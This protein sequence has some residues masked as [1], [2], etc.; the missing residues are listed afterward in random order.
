[1]KYLGNRGSG[2]GRMR[3]SALV[4]LVLPISLA[5]QEP[6]AQSAASVRVA[7]GDTTLAR[8]LDRGLEANRTVH[9]ARARVDAARAERTRTALE[10]APIV[11]AQGAY[12]RQRLSSAGFP[13]ASGAFPDQDVWSAGV[14]LAWELDVFGRTRRAVQAQG[15]RVSAAQEDLRDVHLV[16][17]AELASAYHD[18]RG[19]QERLATAQH[20]ATNQ[21]N[22]LALT[23]DRLAAGRGNAF[24]S[25]RAR[26][27]L[28]TTLAEIPA[29]EGLI[30]ASMHRIAV[31]VGEQPGAIAALAAPSQAS[32]LPD[33][34]VVPRADSL[35]RRRPDVRGAE[36]R[37]AATRALV[38]AARADYLPRLAIAGTAGYTSA[39]AGALGNGATQR[40]A[41]GPVV[42]WPALDLGRVKAG[43]SAARAGEDEALARFEQIHLLAMED[44]E[45]SVVSYRAARER[46]RHLEDAAAASERAAELARMRFREGATDFLQVLDAERTLLA[47]QDQRASARTAAHRAWIGVYRATGGGW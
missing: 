1:M 44:I 33:S 11:N 46:L 47:A 45:T 43:V 24:D 36:R 29:I 3:R 13:G 20:N 12:Q 27:Q 35:A 30:T 32:W 9:A 28:S 18:L 19:A 42:T 22:T 4:A 10:L 34:I 23:L 5:A 39:T 31:L 41:I 40:Y 7:A 25:E 8:L 38:G 15:A 6:R 17:A 16:L 37:V 21:R 14:V 26:A 2:I